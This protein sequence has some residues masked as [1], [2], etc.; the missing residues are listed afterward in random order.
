[1][2]SALEA[3]FGPV[4]SP[5]PDFVEITGAFDPHTHFRNPREDGDGRSEL[6]IPHVSRIFEDANSIGNTS[7]ALLS[8]AKAREMRTRWQALVPAS[9]QMR[10]HVSPLITETTQFDDILGALDD[11]PGTAAALAPKMFLRA[12][13]NSGGSDVGDVR[14]VIPLLRQLFTKSSYLHRNQ[15]PILKIHAEKKFTR[16]GRQISILDRERAA[17]EHDIELILSEIPDARLEICHVS[18]ASTIEAIEHYQ[19][20]GFFVC[21]EIAPHYTAQTIDD[22][23]EDGTGGTGMNANCFCVPLFKSESDR[24]VVHGA[25]LSGKPY[26]YYGGDG[27]CHVEDPTQVKGVKTNARGI[28]VGGQ[29]QIPEAVMS[30]VFEQ[31]FEAGRTVADIQEFVSNRA[32]RVY[33]LPQGTRSVRFVREDWVVPETISHTFADGT[34]ITCRVAMGGEIRKY[35]VAA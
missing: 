33:G 23:F 29:T 18:L 19:N 2:N 7:P 4:K 15:L 1:M 3:L 35:R 5:Y 26:F 10:V 17:I 27:A 12:V 32:R 31:F 14:K 8:S 16:L 25:M 34:T 11:E 30:Y 21:G 22:L 28:S 6:I 20:E 24:R 9:A 13:S